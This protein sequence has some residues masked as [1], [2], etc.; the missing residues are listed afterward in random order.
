MGGRVVKRADLRPRCA[1]VVLSATTATF[2]GSPAVWRSDRVPA[3]WV[4]VANYPG[5]TIEWCD[6]H[7]EAGPLQSR[8]V[9]DFC[10]EPVRF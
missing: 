1:Y 10:A 4:G 3:E 7:R 6:R 2:C 8:T 9:G 5:D